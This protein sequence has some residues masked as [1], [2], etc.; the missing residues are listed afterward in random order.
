MTGII[1]SIILFIDACLGSVDPLVII[2]CCTHIEPPTRM[3][4]ST[5]EGSG[6]ERSSHR[7]PS[8]NGIASWTPGT[9]AQSL[10][11]RLTRPSGLL[12]RAFIMDW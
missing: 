5:L 11:E 4:R 12:G 6:S 9:Q 7:K 10:W 2:F 8:F 3:G 1:Q